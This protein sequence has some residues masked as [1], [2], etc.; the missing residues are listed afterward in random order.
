MSGVFFFFS[1]QL[2][3]WPLQAGSLHLQRTESLCPVG[4]Q[5]LHGRSPVA[6]SKSLTLVSSQSLPSAGSQSLLPVGSQLLAYFQWA[7][8]IY[9]GRSVILYLQRSVCTY[10]QWT[11]SSYFLWTVSTYLQRSVSTFLQCTFLL[12]YLLTNCE[13]NFLYITISKV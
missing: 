1:F 12:E 11:V 7:V 2:N 4:S 8:R 9:I 13:D 3:L 5:S 6:G 10:L